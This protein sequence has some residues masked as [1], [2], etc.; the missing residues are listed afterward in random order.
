VSFVVVH[1][2]V[3]A[4]VLFGVGGGC[5]FCALAIAVFVVVCCAYF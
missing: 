2:V 1:C 3:V 5:F 4:V